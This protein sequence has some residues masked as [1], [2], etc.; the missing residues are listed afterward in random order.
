MWKDMKYS[1][2]GG[3]EIERAH[4]ERRR[5]PVIRNDEEEDMK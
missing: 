2:Q 1:N 4:G 3:Y 5:E